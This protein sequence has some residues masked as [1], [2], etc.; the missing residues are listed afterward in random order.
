MRI[1]AEPNR[2]DVIQ[3]P[4]CGGEFVHFPKI[5]F[6]LEEIENLTVNNEGEV[7]IQNEGTQDGGGYHYSILLHYKCEQ[8]HNGKIRIIHSKGTAYIIAL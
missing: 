6:H 8:G 7:T 5:T 2:I 4:K 3:C 1:T